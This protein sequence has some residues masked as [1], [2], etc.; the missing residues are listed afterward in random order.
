VLPA[1]IACSDYSV[2]TLMNPG[3]STR[4]CSSAC[5]TLAT[6]LSSSCPD[7]LPET[8]ESSLRPIMN[9]LHSGMM[10]AGCGTHSANAVAADL[11]RQCQQTLATWTPTFRQACCAPLEHLKPTSPACAPSVLPVLT[12]CRCS[13]VLG[14]AG[15]DGNCDPTG[16]GP[17]SQGFVPQTCTQACERVFTPFFSDC[18]EVIWGDSPEEYAALRDLSRLC[19]HSGEDITG[20]SS[21]SLC[22]SLSVCLS[23][24][25]SPSVSLSVCLSVCLSASLCVLHSISLFRLSL[26]FAVTR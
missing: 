8:L 26:I 9:L 21:V 10:P 20:T 11:T 14:L 7:G 5:A 3:A 17:V 25:L 18:G 23:L 16:S 13:A 4:F 6:P 15:V 2:Q 1:A 22:V 12:Q 19:T 24:S